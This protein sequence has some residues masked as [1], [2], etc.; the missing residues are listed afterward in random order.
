MNISNFNLNFNSRSSNRKNSVA[1]KSKK[2]Y[3]LEIL[4]LGKN[5]QYE[6][7]PASFTRLLN[8][9]VEDCKALDSIKKSWKG[10]DFITELVE[11]FNF[12]KNPYAHYAVEIK[13]DKLPLHK[14][15]VALACTSSSEVSNNSQLK[16]YLLQGKPAS[17][18]GQDKRQFKGAG[19][20]MMY[21][22]TRI[23]KASNVEKL[24]LDSTND[25]F[26]DALHM[27]KKITN[28]NR[29][30]DYLSPEEAKRVSSITSERYFL[31]EDFQSFIKQISDKYKL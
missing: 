3:D 20:L 9:S 8:S 12:T 16:L 6:L 1:F 28:V 14:K 18:Y 15:I 10:A 26:Y 31:P 5:G 19:E 27:R 29:A 24:C 30:A 17:K 11:K 25:A 13:D 21:G 2:I 23:A 7:V 4:K 22:L